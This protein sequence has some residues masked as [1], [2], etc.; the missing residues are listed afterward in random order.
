M[1]D[2][3]P[4]LKRETEPVGARS[5]VELPLGKLLPLYS[6]VCDLFQVTDQ[7]ISKTDE[8]S[9]QGQSYIDFAFGSDNSRFSGAHRFSVSRTDE[10]R[11]LVTISFASMVCNPQTG[12]NIT[13]PGGGFFHR[14]YAMMLFREAVAEVQKGLSR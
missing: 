12:A 13:P 14:V 7:H 6:R 10:D 5:K 4:A 1:G 9:E 8:S 3:L 11:D 2:S